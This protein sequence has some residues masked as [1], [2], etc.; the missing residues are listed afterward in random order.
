[1]QRRCQEVIEQCVV[2]GENS[3]I[4]SIHDVGAGGLSNA[5]P[6]LI[7]DADLGGEFELRKIP[8]AE[9]GMSPKEI[10]C[11]EAQERYVLAINNEKLAEF[12]AL[13]RRERCPYAVLGRSTKTPQLVLSDE[14]M[15]NKPIDIPMDVL[16]GKT[17]KMQRN[18]ATVSQAHR[19]FVTEDIN[20]SEAIE[21]ILQLPT[22]ASKSLFDYDKR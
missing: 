17:P 5:I 2:Q 6:E 4:I 10:W 20:L 12:E 22:V 13:C 3:P 14:E 18:V 1:M 19:T 9:P 15:A 7:D 8:N 21:R 16:L 11:N